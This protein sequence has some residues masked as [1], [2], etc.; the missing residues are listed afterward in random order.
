MGGFTSIWHW[1]IVLLVIV[2]L[3]GAKKIPE[4]AKGLGSGIKNFK[5]AVKDDEEE[6]KNEPK[7][8]DTQVTQ[9]KVHESSE[10][11]SKQES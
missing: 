1:V 8:L 6:A 4:L 10:I 3:F 2:L 9:A 5:K 7:T 11:K